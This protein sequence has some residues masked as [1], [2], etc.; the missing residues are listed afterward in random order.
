V[1]VGDIHLDSPLPTVNGGGRY[2]GARLL[3]RLHG[4]PVAEAVLPLPGRPAAPDELA[5]MV[6]PA[7][8]EAVAKHCA[9]DGI[10]PP[11]GLPAGGLAPPAGLR[12]A[13]R[14]E[15]ADPPAATVVIATRDRPASLLRCL[16]SVARLDYPAFD[17]IVVDSAPGS[18][19]T[20]AALGGRRWPVRVRYMR[21]PRPGLA[22]AHNAALPGVSGQIVAF[23]DDDVEVDPGWLTAL[24]AP[25]ADPGTACVTGV[26]LPAELETRA[27]LLVEQAGGFCRGFEPRTYRLGGPGDGPL[28]PFAAGRFGSGANMAFRT[29]WL[30]SGGGF[31]AATGAGT[32]ARGGDDLIA[33]LKVITSGAALAYQPAAIVRHWHRRGYDGL[34]RQAFGYGVGFGAYVAASV[35]ARPALL[36]AMLRRA[37][38]ALRHIISPDSAKNAKQEPGFPREL[39]WRERAGMLVGPFAYA[40]S[41][42]RYRDRDRRDRHPRRPG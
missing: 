42:W 20:A 10:Q 25:F 37:A 34:R 26:I 7:V 4:H 40:V 18:G 32:P 14:P 11:D 38:P 27:Q 29:R 16:D 36:P 15:L 13:A 24:A 41:R 22:L 31:D 30:V 39:V 2:R 8:A 3:A 28:F 17:V 23:T 9:A 21:E 35:R 12:C 33:F 5:A 1:L 19:Q 6:W